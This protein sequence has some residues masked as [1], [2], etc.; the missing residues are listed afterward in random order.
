MTYSEEDTSNNLLSTR[1]D[2]QLYVSRDIQA[3][4]VLARKQIIKLSLLS[5]LRRVQSKFWDHFA[6]GNFDM[7]STIVL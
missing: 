6:L 3:N 4:L 7:T 2:K 5:S 1:R